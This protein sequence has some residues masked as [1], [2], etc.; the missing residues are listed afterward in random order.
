MSDF[1]LRLGIAQ[2]SFPS[3]LGSHIN[4]NL[5]F[6]K[7]FYCLAKICINYRN[8]L[9]TLSK[10]INVVVIVELQRFY[11]T[12]CVVQPRFDRRGMIPYLIDMSF[13]VSIRHCKANKPY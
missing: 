11:C 4:W 8:S 12:A 7:V 2:T 3:A 10:S 1:W 13:N 9:T 5:L 6:D